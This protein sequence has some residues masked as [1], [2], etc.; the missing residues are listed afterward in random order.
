MTRA[1][2][3]AGLL[4]SGTAIGQVFVENFDSGLNTWMSYPSIGAETASMEDRNGSMSSGSAEVTTVTDEHGV[5][6]CVDSSIPAGVIDFGMYGFF[7]SGNTAPG[8]QIQCTFT[9]YSADACSGGPT[10]MNTTPANADN[11]WGQTEGTT[12]VPFVVESMFIRCGVAFGNVAPGDVV[13]V[14]G[15]YAGP[16]GTVPVELME[17]DVD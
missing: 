6:N 11:V 1:I 14:D 4:C 10:S 13:R 2:L 15:I 9:F 5:E 16:M 7:P 17:F 3:L 8:Q 12:A